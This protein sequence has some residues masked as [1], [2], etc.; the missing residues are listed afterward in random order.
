MMGL[1]DSML[2]REED[3]E[4]PVCRFFKDHYDVTYTVSAAT[5]EIAYAVAVTATELEALEALVDAAADANALE[6]DRAV[7]E[8]VESAFDDSVDASAFTDRLSY[9]RQ[10]VEALLEVW[11]D[12]HHGDIDVCYLPV[13]AESMVA[14]FVASCQRYDGRADD[15]FELPDSFDEVTSLVV[16]LKQA[17]DADENRVTVHHGRV[18]EFEPP[19]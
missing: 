16:R 3:E 15:L 12:V 17:A 11:T 18:P 9:P 4:Q 10:F 7:V 13:G 14:A 1:L 19:W 6:D 2:G 5:H 8:A